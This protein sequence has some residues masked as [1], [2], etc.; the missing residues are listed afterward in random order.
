MSN[1]DSSS[2]HVYFFSVFTND[3]GRNQTDGLAFFSKEEA[4]HEA[5]TATGEIIRDMDGKMHP[6][7]DWRMDVTDATGNLIYRF[8]FKAEAL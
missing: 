7:L 2:E 4:W 6:G 1:P 8:S 3:T 5:S